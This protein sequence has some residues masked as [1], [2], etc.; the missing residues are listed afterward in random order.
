[1]ELVLW[2]AAAK[3]SKKILSA[4]ARNAQIGEFGWLPSSAAMLAAVRNAKEG[5]TDVML[6]NASGQSQKVVTTS[7][8]EMLEMLISPVRPVAALATY[9]RGGQ[10]GATVRFID[11]TG[12]TTSWPVPRLVGM[13]RWSPDGNKFLAMSVYRG[14][15]SQTAVPAGWYSLNPQ[16]GALDKVAEPDMKSKSPV[17]L[18]ASAFNLALATKS[19][20]GSAQA[21]V[22]ILHDPAVP[23]KESSFAVVS[24][25]G[26]Q[27]AL[28]PSGSAVAYISQGVVM[29]RSLVHVPK[30]AFEKA[31]DAALRQVVMSKAKQ[32]GVALHMFAADMDGAFPDNKGWEDKLSPYSRNRQMLDGF[33][34]TFG[35]GPL[36][37]DPSKKS[38]G[39]LSGPG[40]RAVVYADGHVV[41]EADQG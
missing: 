31:R 14:Q 18:M 23:P 10:D 27:P 41:W 39:F 34:Y 29:V 1:M 7:P 4:D 35:G 16:T 24:T 22:I 15:E 5:S 20:P 40:G 30:E 36:S 37:G 12:K 2:S 8:D 3:S 32:I 6:L 21:P 33:N 9:G 11:S 19:I 28:S 38:L 13:F 25:D 26:A 17:G